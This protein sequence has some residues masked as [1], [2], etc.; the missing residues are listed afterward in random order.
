M[1]FLIG[2]GGEND[3]H[4]LRLSTRRGNHIP[5]W[6]QK[7]DRAPE[8]MHAARAVVM[9]GHEGRVLRSLASS[10]NCIGMAFANRRTCIEPD[11]VTMILEEDGFVEVAQVA[12]VMT[13]DLI[14]YEFDGE[15]SHV[16]VVVENEPDLRNGGSTIRVLSQW[17]F[18]GEYLHEYR[19]VHPS[20]GRPVRFYTERRT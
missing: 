8:A 11:Q 5:N 2:A 1:A 17:G 12:A 15:I 6:Q 10:Y 14:V 7:R 13:G 3:R 16:A 9:D 20:L 18:D 4:A 19:D